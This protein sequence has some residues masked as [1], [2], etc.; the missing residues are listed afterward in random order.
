MF[1]SDGQIFTSATV[2]MRL[3]A[4]QNNDESLKIKMVEF[5]PAS[6]LGV[7]APLV[8][9]QSMAAMYEMIRLV[10]CIVRPTASYDR[11]SLDLRDALCH[12]WPWY[13]DMTDDTMIFSMMRWEFSE[14]AKMIPL[15]SRSRIFRSSIKVS[16]TV[17]HIFESAVIRPWLGTNN[18]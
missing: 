1:S 10:V 4:I 2:Q 15:I 5:G 16:E 12:V 7:W 3:T 14:Y 18:Y 6:S 11:N 9:A 13:G 17:S 8:A